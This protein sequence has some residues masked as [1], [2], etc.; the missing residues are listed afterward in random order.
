[1]S[2][3]SAAIPTFEIQLKALGRLLDKAE[4][5]ATAKKFDVSVLLNSRLA[6]DMLPLTRQ[7]Q[8]ACDFARRGAARLAGIEPGSVEDKETTIAEL[9]ARIDNTIAFVK[10]V[11]PAAIDGSAKRVITLPLGPNAKGEMTGADYL[12]HFVLPNFYFQSTIAYAILRH[13]GVEI[14]KLDFMHGVPLKRV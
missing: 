5:H 2:M 13:N 14:G 7:I 4:A 1:M 3:S 12:N 9:K 6:P 10:S 11:D 8:L